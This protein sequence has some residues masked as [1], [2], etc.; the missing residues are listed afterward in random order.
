MATARKLC[1]LRPKPST[2]SL[3]NDPH[4]EKIG[5][6][7]KKVDPLTPRLWGSTLATSALARSPTTPTCIQR[8]QLSYL[9][10]LQSKPD[11][12]PKCRSNTEIR[13]LRP[14]PNQ[15]LLQN[16]LILSAIART[17]PTRQT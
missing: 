1:P 15:Y 14:L 2:A 16:L 12:F 17:S 6:L 8:A 11:I 10:V 4:V 9:G 7:S 3:A 5:N 13:L